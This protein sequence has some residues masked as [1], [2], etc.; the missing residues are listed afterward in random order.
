M[1][2]TTVTAATTGILAAA[3]TGAVVM[4]AG[5]EAVAATGVK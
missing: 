4:A 3:G 1:A 2:V 5:T